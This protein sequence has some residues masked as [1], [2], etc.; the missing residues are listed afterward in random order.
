MNVIIFISGSA[1]G[2][3][4][5][6]ITTIYIKSQSSKELTEALKKEHREITERHRDFVEKILPMIPSEVTAKNPKLYAKNIKM[7]DLLLER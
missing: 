6:K 3:L 1:T 2:A 7:T 5:L 4:L